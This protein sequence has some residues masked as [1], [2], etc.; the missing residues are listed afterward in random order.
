M[1]QD[2]E[3][4][5]KYLS[6]MILMLVMPLGLVANGMMSL[7]NA[8]AYGVMT[9]VNYQLQMISVRVSQKKVVFSVI[10]AVP[11]LMNSNHVIELVKTVHYLVQLGK[12]QLEIGLTQKLLKYI[13]Q[14]MNVL[15]DVKMNFVK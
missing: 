1:L 11:G 2:L 15:K 4:C 9:I 13:V 6:V 10:L 14:M 5:V 3:S 7:L 12:K 8:M